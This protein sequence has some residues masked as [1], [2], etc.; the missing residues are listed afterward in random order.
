M[1]A[2]QDFAFEIRGGTE[3]H[4]RRG[5]H[6]TAGGGHGVKVRVDAGLLFALVSKSTVKAVASQD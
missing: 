1:H 2:V 4:Q 3:A 6:T 5:A